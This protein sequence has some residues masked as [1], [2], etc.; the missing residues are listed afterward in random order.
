M[1]RSREERRKELDSPFI[2]RLSKEAHA[3]DVKQNAA[4]KPFFR[5][6]DDDHRTAK[7]KAFAR[8][9]GVS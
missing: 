1:A 5:R 3:N 7:S 2:N 4:P 9:W 6:S 8:K